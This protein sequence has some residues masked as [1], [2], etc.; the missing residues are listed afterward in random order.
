MERSKPTRSHA[1]AEAAAAAMQCKALMR[2]FR[3]VRAVAVAVSSSDHLLL[4]AVN[5]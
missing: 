5:L 4:D 1:A 2:H 3:S